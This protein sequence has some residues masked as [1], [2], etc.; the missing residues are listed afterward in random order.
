MVARIRAER[1]IFGNSQIRSAGVFITDAAGD[2]AFRVT[3]G[4]YTL[5]ASQYGY[6]T[7]YSGTLYAAASST[8]TQNISVTAIGTGNA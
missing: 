1:E 6:Y 8:A 2:Y 5:R 4:S 3:P 7:A